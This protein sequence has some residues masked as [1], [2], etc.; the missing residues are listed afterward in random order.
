[1]ARVPGWPGGG[2]RLPMPPGS[3]QADNVGRPTRAAAVGTAR[4]V[5][6]RR[7]AAADSGQVPRALRKS[8]K[9]KAFQ[10]DPETPQKPDGTP[11]SQQC[12]MSPAAHHCGAM[13]IRQNIGQNPAGTPCGPCNTRTC[14]RG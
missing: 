1:M 3:R 2:L 7:Y 8:L 13:L 9:I 6:H 14:G 4:R 10:A 12:D 11:L 5:F